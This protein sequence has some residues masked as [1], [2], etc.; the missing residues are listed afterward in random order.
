ME[1]SLLI[2]AAVFITI[3]LIFVGI[4]AALSSRDKRKEW[5]ERLTGRW[6][7]AP[8]E[9]MPEGLT[10]RRTGF[11]RFLGSMGEAATPKNA[12]ELSHLR[13]TLVKA[14]YR[15]V[16]APLIFFGA[17]LCLAMLL[18]GAFALL[19]ASALPTMPHTHTMLLFV[20]SAVVGFYAPNLWVQLKTQSRQ[21]KILAGF[22]DALDLMVVCVEAGLGL[23]AAMNQVGAEMKLS[24]PLL[25]EEF[26]L[27]NAELRAGQSRQNALRNLSLRTG[28]EDVNNFATLLIQT[29]SFGT[30]I[31]QALRVH[32]DAMRTK[33]HHRA[34]E[35][36]A[37]LPV[38]LLFPLIFFIFPSLF[39]VILGPAV[40]Q[41]MRIL[42]PTLAAE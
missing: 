24:H 31:A 2:T 17:K 5:R 3:V 30:S 16:D 33:R 29:D 11:S 35:A 42:L 26:K 22:P 27:V 36:A 41:I 20:L 39:V 7:N 19:R 4:S 37:K 18:P 34:E 21:Q 1:M 23:D 8:S 6:E 12:D 13:R 25:S 38:K 10:P 9:A 32:A 28:L 40:V 14:G 15:G